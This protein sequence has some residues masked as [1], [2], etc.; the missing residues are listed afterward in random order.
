MAAVEFRESDGKQAHSKLP[1]SRTPASSSP[2][3]DSTF[4]LDCA[5]EAFERVA[6]RGK[7][8]KV[9]FDVSGG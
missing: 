3:S 6:A 1:T 9:V 7:R 2:I 5:R 8:G 4:P